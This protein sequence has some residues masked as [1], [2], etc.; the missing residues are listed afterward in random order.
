MHYPLTDIHAHFEI[1]RLVSYQNTAERNYFHRRTDGQTD[2]RTDVG[3]FL[4][5]SFLEE[6]K[7]LKIDYGLCV[8][9]QSKVTPTDRTHA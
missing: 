8:I 5:G 6:K 4:I 9:E 7:I 1:N 2:G 3:S